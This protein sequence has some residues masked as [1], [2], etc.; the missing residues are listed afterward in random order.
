[1]LRAAHHPTWTSRA[2]AI[3]SVIAIAIATAPGARS[4]SKRAIAPAR[5]STRILGVGLIAFVPNR[6]MYPGMRKTP[7]ESTP[8]RFA[9][10]SDFAHSSAMAGATPAA[11]NS[12]PAKRW[13]SALKITW[14]SVFNG[15]PAM[16]SNFCEGA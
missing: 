5:F 8:R 16:C 7:C 6:S 4:A 3:A 9:H 12:A 11:T 1:M 10:T 2:R 15:I 13:R 14:D